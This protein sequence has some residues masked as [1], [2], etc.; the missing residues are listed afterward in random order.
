MKWS[1]NEL[2]IK[3][4]KIAIGDCEVY[5][6]TPIYTILK[7]RQKFAMDYIEWNIKEELF[8]EFLNL[9]E[10]ILKEEFIWNDDVVEIER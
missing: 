4:R 1:I 7:Q 5:K 8:K 9:Q 2:Y 10:N 6:N 3:S